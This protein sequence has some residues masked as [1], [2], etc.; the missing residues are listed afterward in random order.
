MIEPRHTVILT[1][2]IEADGG[3]LPGCQR[4]YESF[5]ILPRLLQVLQAW[6]LPL[7][8]FVEGD[9]LD[10]HADLIAP[11]IAYGATFESHAYDHSC[12][13]LDVESR[14][15]NIERGL[16]AYRTCFSASPWGFRAPCGMIEPEELSWLAR[17]GVR[18]DSSIFPSFF[19]GRFNHTA[20]PLSPYR[21]AK[22][23]LIE[24]PVGTLGVS[25]YPL[26]LSYAQLIGWRAFRWLF[27]CCPKPP[28]FIFNFHLHD[29]WRGTWHLRPDVP[30]AI[31]YGYNLTLR[32]DPF[33]IFLKCL[34]LMRA[35]NVHFSTTRAWLE[36]LDTSALPEYPTLRD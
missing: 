3:A 15:D 6:Q 13:G 29:L 12:V 7:T 30:K 18:Y 20:A 25:R 33:A 10:H 27:T 22:V 17:A 24:L 5:A 32:G 34:N 1:I 35:Q 14:L 19:P 26:G 8:A 28:C 31:R 11:L 9:I 16:H 21:H 2:D 36:S 4:T 23:G